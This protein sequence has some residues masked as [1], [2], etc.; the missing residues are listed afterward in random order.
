MP[1]EHIHIRDGPEHL[2]VTVFLRTSGQHEADLL[3]YHMCA[4]SIRRLPGRYLDT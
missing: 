2:E 3:G 4:Q 1:V